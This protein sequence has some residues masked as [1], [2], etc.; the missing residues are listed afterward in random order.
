MGSPLRVVCSVTTKI[1]F[2]PPPSPWPRPLPECRLGRWTGAP[3]KTEGEAAKVSEL[4]VD[5]LRDLNAVD[6][7]ADAPAAEKKDRF[8]PASAGSAGGETWI[9]GRLIEELSQNVPAG[10]AVTANAV[11]S[12][13]ILRKGKEQIQG[14]SEPAK[15]QATGTATQPFVITQQPLSALP[16]TQRGPTT[17]RLLS[18]NSAAKKSERSAH[19]RISGFTSFSPRTSASSCSNHG[20]GFYYPQS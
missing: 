2:T 20:W 4:K 1:F 11:E 9:Q 10:R 17:R 3:A 8:A 6:A 5:R 16:M 13:G 19:H 18:P 7:R 12:Q 15:L 14:V